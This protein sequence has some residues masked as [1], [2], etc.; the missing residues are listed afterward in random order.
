[1]SRLDRDSQSCYSIIQNTVSNTGM[2]IERQEVK[3]L[4]EINKNVSQNEKKNR[5]T[6]VLQFNESVKLVNQVFKTVQ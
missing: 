1:M 2:I 4:K 6:L 5:V 3:L